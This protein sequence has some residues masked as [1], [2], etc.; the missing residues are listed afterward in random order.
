MKTA[1]KNS[2]T[3]SPSCAPGATTSPDGKACAPGSA[4]H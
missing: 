4:P 1:H 2:S 3:T